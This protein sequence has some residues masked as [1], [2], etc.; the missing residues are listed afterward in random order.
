MIVDI[1][2]EGVSMAVPQRSDFGSI[3]H[4]RGGVDGLIEALRARISEP[5]GSGPAH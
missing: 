4:D 5:A 3:I 1:V 2:V